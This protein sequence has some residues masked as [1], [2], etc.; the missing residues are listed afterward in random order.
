MLKAGEAVEHAFCDGRYGY[1]VPASGEADVNGLRIT[2]RDGAI[3]DVAVVRIA[4]IVDS[5][6]VMVDA[7]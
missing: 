1:L 3:E 6:V 4:A 7:P 5:E 2:A